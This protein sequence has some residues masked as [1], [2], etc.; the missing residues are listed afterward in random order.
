MRAA[1]A[2]LSSSMLRRSLYSS[3]AV[4]FVYCERQAFIARFS[5]RQLKTTKRFCSLAQLLKAA[6]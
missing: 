1:A 6:R 5:S 4:S 3:K 2:F